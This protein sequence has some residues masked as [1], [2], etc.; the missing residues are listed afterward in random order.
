MSTL[1]LPALARRLG[2]ALS[3]AIEQQAVQGRA[4]FTIDRA[5]GGA[6]DAPPTVSTGVQTVQV[7]ATNA[8]GRTATV[9]ANVFVQPAGAR[10][11]AR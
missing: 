11:A 1:H 5:L 6:D 8:A 10:V 4:H 9:M 3:G 2:A 7:L